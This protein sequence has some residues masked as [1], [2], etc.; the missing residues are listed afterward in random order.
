MRAR[1]AEGRD[2]GPAGVRGLPSAAVTHY[3]V[4]GLDPADVTVRI[5]ESPMGRSTPSGGSTTAPG[6][7][8]AVLNAASDARTKLL[9]K[10]AERFSAKAEELAIEPAMAE[11]LGKALAGTADWMRNK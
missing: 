11:R 4:L 3:E 1:H 8:P 6:T 10:L 9:G 5:G 7:A 2:P